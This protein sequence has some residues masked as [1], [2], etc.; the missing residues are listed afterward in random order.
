M[1]VSGSASFQLSQDPELVK[2]L[3]RTK[4]TLW[5]T[6]RNSASH[7]SQQRHHKMAAKAATTLRLQDIYQQA[8][9]GHLASA[10]ISRLYATTTR[11][12]IAKATTA[13]YTSPTNASSFKVP[14]R[15]SP[16]PFSQVGQAA[17]GQFKS[18]LILLWFGIVV[19]LFYVVLYVTVCV[20]T[21]YIIYQICSTIGPDARRQLREVRQNGSIRYWQERGRTFGE[22][23]RQMY[24]YY[25][26]HQNKDEA[27]N[28][29][30]AVDRAISN[31][32][33]WLLLLAPAFLLLKATWLSP[34]GYGMI[35][36]NELEGFEVPWYMRIERRQV[37]S[38]HLAPEPSPA[39]R[40]LDDHLCE[41]AVSRYK[42]PVVAIPP[43]TTIGAGKV[44]CG[45]I[46]TKNWT[47]TIF[48]TVQASTELEST[49]P[50]A[51]TNSSSH[52]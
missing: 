35:P 49:C 31:N 37:G 29:F 13:S 24:N 47:T 2:A 44:T 27:L 41:A 45:P 36:W 26:W 12:A 32:L 51:L 52:S 11:T 4:T 46:H 34:A 17:L 14:I 6:Y 42:E 7:A 38:N 10:R 50:A 28:R 22:R 1:F 8:Y 33:T 43:S 23:A 25:R 3:R 16:Q 21:V 40:L 9:S 39:G 5:T 30:R 48:K 18:L 19:P 15:D 20:G